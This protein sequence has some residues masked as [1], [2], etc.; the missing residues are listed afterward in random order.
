MTLIQEVSEE[1]SGGEMQRDTGQE[2]G[3]KPNATNSNPTHRK[4]T[5]PPQSR[6]LEHCPLSNTRG[7][8]QYLG[9][10]R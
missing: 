5:S 6:R 7:C 10:R 9:W 4:P 3:V 1:K 8:N 2:N